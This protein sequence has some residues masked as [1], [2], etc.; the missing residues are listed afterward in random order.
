MSLTICDT[1]SCV[2]FGSIIGSSLLPPILFEI[3]D[4]FFSCN[5]LRVFSICSAVFYLLNVDNALG[6]LV[7]FIDAFL[8]LLIFARKYI[9]NLFCISFV[10]T[11]LL[12]VIELVR[13]VTGLGEFTAILEFSFN[14]RLIFE[15]AIEGLLSLSTVMLFKGFIGIFQ[16][17]I[18]S[19]ALMKSNAGL[20][21]VAECFV[22]TEPMLFLIDDCLATISVSI[23]AL[24][25]I[26]SCVIATI[27]LSLNG[28]GGMFA[29]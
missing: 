27:C 23:L 22:D 6:V 17:E 28:N 18:S 2:I 25:L 26:S 11:A 5:A 10:G 29:F 24:S 13:V 20:L 12:G 1:S 14:C 8:A 15:A 9:D 4:S 7:S 3:L 21:V 16:P 19:T